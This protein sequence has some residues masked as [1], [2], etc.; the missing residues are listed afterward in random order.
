MDEVEQAEKT[1]ANIGFYGGFPAEES[2]SPY[3]APLIDEASGFG[4]IRDGAEAFPEQWQQNE[5]EPPRYTLE[6]AD[7][8]AEVHIMDSAWTPAKPMMKPK[9]RKPKPQNSNPRAT[10]S[11]FVD[12][13]CKSRVVSSAS[14]K[15]ES[16]PAITGKLHPSYLHF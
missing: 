3:H 1:D 16:I 11:V 2:P 5:K 14:V 10:S 9:S 12:L 13:T 7:A 15:A 6:E 4:D 8:M